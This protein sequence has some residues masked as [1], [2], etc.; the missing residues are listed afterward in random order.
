MSAGG[1]ANGVIFLRPLEGKKEEVSSDLYHHLC[2][3]LLK[4]L[5]SLNNI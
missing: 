2:L 5:F 4:F 1:P 3:G